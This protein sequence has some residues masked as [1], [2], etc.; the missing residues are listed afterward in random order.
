MIGYKYKL[1][2]DNI[3]KINGITIGGG[4]SP[5]L[6]SNQT[7]SVSGWV[8]NGTNYDYTFSNP[9]ITTNVSVDMIPYDGSVLSVQISGFFPK[10]T[11]YS[12]Y[13]IISCQIAPSENILCNI[14]ITQ[15]S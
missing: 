2:N 14:I 12:G 9:N 6:L 8:L 10:I 13:C 15:V 7:L 11:S 4:S 1:I 5:T 3:M